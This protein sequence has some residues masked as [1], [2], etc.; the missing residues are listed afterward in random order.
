MKKQVIQRTETIDLV[1]GKKV[2]FDYDGN[3]FSINREVPEYRHYNVPK[4]VE[5]VWKKTIINNLLEEVENSIG[6]EK[7]VKVT[8]LLAIYGHSNNIQL[9]EALLED[10]TLDTFSKILYLED[11]NREKLGVNISIKYKILKIE[12]P[13]SYITDLND[14]ILDYKSKLLNSPITIDESFKQN[15]ALKYYDFSDENIIRRIEN[16]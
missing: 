4:D 1:N 3:L 5:D 16:I 8:K 2:F 7:T 12:D 11:L 13:K 15:Y 10:D 14:K 6:H 9:L